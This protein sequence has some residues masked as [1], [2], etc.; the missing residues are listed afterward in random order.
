[1]TNEANCDVST[2]RVTMPGQ[3]SKIGKPR[4]SNHVMPNWR[5]KLMSSRAVCVF[6]QPFIA[7]L[8]KTCAPSLHGQV[9]STTNL[10]GGISFA[11]QLA[12]MGR[13]L[14]ESI[15]GGGQMNMTHKNV[16]AQRERALENEFFYEVDKKLLDDLRQKLA[17]EEAKE[18]LA[19]AGHIDDAT[20][21]DELVESG[22]RPESLAAVN[23][24]PL[25][26]VAW[27]THKLPEKERLTVLQAGADEGVHEQSPAYELLEHWLRNEPTDN[28]AHVWEHY[29]QTLSNTLTDDAFAALK[30]QVMSRAQAVAKS[31]RGMLGFGRLAP[32]EERT[33]G[34]LEDA[35]NES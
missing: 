26:L 22:I 16:F 28:L 27:S 13:D 3:S 24:I 25:I 21:L 5:L 19:V 1:M 20:L 8:P 32:E 7:N 10:D 6:A 33:L 23:L 17:Q 15:L 35:F 4:A 11:L 31:A 34:L 9:K 30:K 12:W 18:A 14:G 29:V 2:S